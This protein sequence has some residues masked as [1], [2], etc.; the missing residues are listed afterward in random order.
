MLDS[1]HFLDRVTIILHRPRFP[2]NIGAAV[3]AAFNMGIS[4][5]SLI[6]PEDCDLTRIL[7]MATH[8]AADLVENMEVHSDLGAALKP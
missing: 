6:S 3:R 1:S 2:E 8:A 5:L 4:R 7:K